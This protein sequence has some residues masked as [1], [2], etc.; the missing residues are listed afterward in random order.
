MTMTLPVMSYMTRKVMAH[1]SSQETSLGLA[2]LP[3]SS[4]QRDSALS[5]SA[6]SPVA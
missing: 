1:L 3:P 4:T 5:M 2:L 6:W